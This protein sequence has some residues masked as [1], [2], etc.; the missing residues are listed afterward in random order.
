MKSTARRE[1]THPTPPMQTPI[2]SGGGRAEQ[3]PWDGQM[4]PDCASHGPDPRTARF[5][6]LLFG[7]LDPLSPAGLGLLNCLSLK[8]PGKERQMKSPRAMDL[9]F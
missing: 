8:N 3:S 7:L 2:H 4:L 1:A 5:L 6:Q 9:V